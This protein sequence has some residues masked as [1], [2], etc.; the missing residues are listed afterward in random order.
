MKNHGTGTEHSLPQTFSVSV[1]AFPRLTGVMTSSAIGF[2]F[3]P[4]II[5]HNK[6]SR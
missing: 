1:S 4:L 5:I 3:D 2:G 6:N